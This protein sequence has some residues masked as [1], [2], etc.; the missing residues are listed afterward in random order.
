MSPVGERLVVVLAVPVAEPAPVPGVAPDRLAAALLADAVDAAES[1]AAAGVAVLCPPGHAEAVTAA[2]AFDTTVWTSQEP[3]VLE[4]A[5]RAAAAGAR[6]TVVLASDAP[7]L[8]GLLV[9]KVFRGLGRADVAISPDP[10][11][12]ASAIGLRLPL[13]EWID[14]IDLDTPGVVDRIVE[15]APRRSLVRLT[16]GWR[17][18]RSA[19][20]LAA[21]GGAVEG[22][23]LTRALLADDP[24]RRG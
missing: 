5:S 2:A 19:A 17:R 14:E 21:L 16:P 24:S 11:G 12:F 10:R 15:A 18:L 22:A 8:P 6:Q 7:H 20:D 4:A 1:L 3:S 23:D 9:G 13:A